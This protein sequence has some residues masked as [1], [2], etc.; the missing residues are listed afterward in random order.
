M[1]SVNSSQ[2][3]RFL[4]PEALEQISASMARWYGPPVAMA[5]VPGNVWAQPGGDFSGRIA[6]GGF[7]TAACLVEDLG[8]RAKRALRR[9]SRRQLTTSNAGFS[10]LSDLISETT[11]AGKRQDLFF[12]KAGTTRVVGATNSLWR[13]G[14]QPAAGTAASAAPAGVA[15]TRA[16][17]GALPF[18][19][20]AVGGD[21]THFVGAQGLLAT[22]APTALLMYDR[23][24]S[25]AKTM[26][27]TATE[28][29]SGSPTRYQNTVAGSVDSAEGNFL[30][31]ECG[32]ALAAT[33][34]NWATCLYTNQ[35]GTTGRT[36]PTLA[37]N[38]ANIANRIDHPV[39]Q[40][41][42]P[43]AAGDIGIRAL[44]QM[45]CSAAV[46]TGTID[47]VIG[48]PIAWLPFPALGLPSI[49]DGINTAFNLVRI[50]DDACL[51]FLEPFAAATTASTYTGTVTAVAG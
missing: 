29:V 16:T 37:G 11:V 40:W 41:F 44:T 2:L 35:A 31:V 5:H 43:L 4:G 7:A 22:A 28:A 14:N 33:A 21:T 23:I 26:N 17:L 19:N 24:Y 27:S 50:F 47:F 10:S 8:R 51:A 6:A 12:Q 49:V 18:N 39:G 3:E 42:A 13:V 25:V 15:P 45:Q 34:H 38:S 46:A 1:P 30:F 20:A 9:W 32:T 48:H 36:L